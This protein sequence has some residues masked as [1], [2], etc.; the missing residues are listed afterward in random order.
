M[1][2]SMNLGVVADIHG[3]LAGLQQALACLSHR[4]VDQIVC[5]GD[6]V[7]KGPQSVEVVNLLRTEGI[8]CIA[9]N[10]DREAFEE[11]KFDN[12]TGSFLEEL[13]PTLCLDRKS[14]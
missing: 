11:Q 5:A 6:L 4:K 3:D 13:P 1:S 9:G 7:K 8:L 12:E 10:H 2:L 14:T